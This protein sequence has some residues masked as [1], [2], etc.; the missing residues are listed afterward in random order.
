LH[1]KIA[2][3]DDSVYNI[4]FLINIIV[5]AAAYCYGVFGKYPKASPLVSLTTNYKFVSFILKRAKPPV[6][7]VPN[8]ELVVL[9][10]YI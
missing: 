8:G 10:M 5:P 1:V 9:R 6:N 7:F 3:V 4:L 2:S